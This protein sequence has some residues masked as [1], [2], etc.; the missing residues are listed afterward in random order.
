MCFPLKCVALLTDITEQHGEEDEAVRGPQ[1]HY[2]QVHPEVED[3]EDL[4]FGK[5]QDKD[6]SK[7]C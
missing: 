6:S 1:Q 3:L 4:R 5:C 7:L 2:G